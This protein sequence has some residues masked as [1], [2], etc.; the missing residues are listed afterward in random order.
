MY[1]EIE[2]VP[3]IADILIAVQILQEKVQQISDEDL[4]NKL[5]SFD[6]RVKLS[7]FVEDGLEEF[8]YTGGLGTHRS[9]LE[10]AYVLYCAPLG[11][12]DKGEVCRQVMKE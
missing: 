12:N 2:D 4:V 9:V 5:Q 8:F 3:K 7:S 1:D 10:N 11:L 6:F